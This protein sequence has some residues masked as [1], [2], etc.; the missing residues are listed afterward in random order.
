[1]S[2]YVRRNGA[3]APGYRKRHS[4]LIG[5][6]IIALIFM[7]IIHIPFFSPAAYASVQ[8]P[9][10]VR[11]GL[12]YNS[13]A[14]EHKAAPS[15][16]VYSEYGVSMGRADISGNSS[17]L[18][19]FSFSGDSE[20]MML[21]RHTYNKGFAVVTGR[22]LVSVYDVSSRVRA[23][24]QKGYDPQ[25]A[26]L[27][28]W[29]LI[30]A[31][32]DSQGAAQ[33]DIEATM[34]ESF[35]DFGFTAE[36]LTG[37]YIVV[38]IG[39]IRQFI[40]DAGAENL[41][42]MPKAPA[43]GE[44]PALIEIG[45]KLYRGAIELISEGNNMTAINIVPLEGYLY[46]VVP[47]EIEASSSHEALK[48]QATAA[49]TYSVITLGKHSDYGFDM[50][51]TT[52]CQVYGGYESENPR[53]SLAVDD[54][55]GKIVTYRGAPAEV[56]YFSS[57]GGHTANVKHV[58][59][60]E[61]NYPYLIGVEDKYE[62]GLSNHYL[63]ETVY[64][65]QEIKARLAS[66]GVDV[67]DVTG[68]AVTGISSSGHAIEVTVT[69]T[70][71]SKVYT[72]ASCRSFLP[73]LYSQ[74][75]TIF[76]TSAGSSAGAGSQSYTAISASGALTKMAGGGD[77]I[78]TSGKLDRYKGNG[79]VAIS[80]AGYVSLPAGGVS[81]H[82]IGRGWGHGVGMSQEGA[83]GMAN[84]GFTYIEILTHYF[85]GCEVG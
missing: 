22:D 66:G 36:A 42:I 27:N 39:N 76:A 60:S 72:N 55:A 70:R 74:M 29:V 13:S 85:P 61:R 59:N 31:F 64:T 30:V 34:A 69:G 46:G 14:A 78:G 4:L 37:K 10:S 44:K 58:W 8:I 35:P 47:R 81:F 50:C 5:I 65:A 11:I 32:Y 18:F 16:Q 52:H 67:G 63:W 54:T 57:S 53:S 19:D 75:Y 2:I 68:V 33:S 48:A 7:G 45:G 79:G 49:R 15:Y 77:A 3:C 80:G 73:N 43:D 41:R 21:T 24:Q 25:L 82:F 20:K 6:L 17:H 26:Y 12:N 84:A 40:F 1:M 71:G 9:F 28:G 23:L 83:K 38:A 62:S 51:S 56:Y